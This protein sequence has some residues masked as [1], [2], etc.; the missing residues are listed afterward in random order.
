MRWGIPT[1][2]QCILCLKTD[3]ATME[4]M[5]KGKYDRFGVELCEP[6][7]DMVKERKGMTILN[8]REDLAKDSLAGTAKA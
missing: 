2:P 5:K 6:H 3:G 7:E 4:A 8:G 1:K